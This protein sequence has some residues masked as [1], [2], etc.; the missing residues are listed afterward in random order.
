MKPAPV[1]VPAKLGVT[2][3]YPT[4][5]DSRQMGQSL[6][7]IVRVLDEDGQAVTDAR[8]TL[9]IIGPSGELAGQLT[10]TA[11]SGDVYRSE[12]WTIPHRMRAGNWQIQVQAEASDARGAAT[13]VFQVKNSVSEDLLKKYG[14]WVDAPR[15]KDI[16]PDLF[17]EQG[18]AQ[19][20]VIVWGGLLPVQH[21]FVENW[22]EVQWRQG[23]F[24]LSGADQV[25]SFMLSQLGDFGF[26]PTRALGPFERVKFKGWDAWQVRA[27]GQFSRYDE[28]WMIFYSPEAGKTYAIGTMVVLPPPGIDAHAALR[29]GFEVHP[30]AHASGTAPVP[31]PRL[32]HPPELESPALGTRFMGAGEP[33]VL[34]WTA[35]ESLEADEYYRVKVDYNYS[36]SNT[37]LE[38]W[39]RDTQLVL[40]PDLYD[41]PNCGV[42]NWRVTLMKK[43]GADADG[44]PEGVALSYPSLYWYVEWLHPADSSAPFQPRCPNPQT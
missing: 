3:L 40:P 11:G 8:V 27:R 28:Q 12:S 18:D 24:D 4:G 30:E 14:F 21:I 29:N 10:A 32:L 33:I 34:R 20:G 41:V 22:L 44:Q 1:T 16:N 25:R 35:L 19:D 38:Y 23:Q 5:T 17:K 31:L 43:S 26:Y 6:K 9:S 7:P 37:A 2:V 42:F 39:T 15:L 36:E 13:Q